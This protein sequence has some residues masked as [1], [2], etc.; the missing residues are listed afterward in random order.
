MKIVFTISVISFNSFCAFLSKPSTPIIIF[1]DNEIKDFYFTTIK[2]TGVEFVIGSDAHRPEHIG[3]FEKA[4]KQAKEASID[5][6]RIK[7]IKL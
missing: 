5:F 3:N 7:N 6:N 4:I 2:N 1:C